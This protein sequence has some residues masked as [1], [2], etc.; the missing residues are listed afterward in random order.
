MGRGVGLAGNAARQRAPL[1]PL[2]DELES[3]EAIDGVAK[4]LA[5]TVRNAIPP[6]VLKEALS[7]TWLGHALHPMLTDV[8]IGSFTS[9]SLLDLLDGDR[10][11]SERLIAIGIVASVPTALTG[12]HDWADSE[13]ADDGVRRVGL[14][15]AAS[16][17]TALSL[18][19]AS[20]AA[21]RRGA[22]RTGVLL[23]GLGAAALAAGGYL[24]GHL[25]LAKGIGADQT[26]FDPGPEDWTSAA[27]APQL[28]PGHPAR[29]VV[30]DT[31][32]MLVQGDDR[33]LAI[34]DRCSHRGCS[35]SDG[36]IDGHSVTCACHGSRFDL[37]DGSLERGPATTPQ[38]AYETRE[39]EGRIEIRLARGPTG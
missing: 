29:V 1:A 20:L 23:G 28:A 35:L 17:T 9:A 7:G 19:A 12:V 11:A 3:A 2:I 36:Q 25:T 15:H 38:P 16:N 30:G 37:R 4:P 5:T 14:V 18:Y 13:P 10:R 8:V 31:P 6:G 39:R 22:R 34:H 33:V 21:R 27:D 32:V 24:G 26:I